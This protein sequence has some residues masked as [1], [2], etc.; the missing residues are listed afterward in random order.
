MSNVRKILDT[1]GRDVVADALGV[2]GKSLSA[3]AVSNRC[4]SSWWL[5]L[6]QLCA[7]GGIDCPADLFA[8]KAAPSDN[9]D[10]MA[11]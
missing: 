5:I 6:S 3:A 7:A 8:F 9:P 1:L 2:T 11:S 10:R 4:P